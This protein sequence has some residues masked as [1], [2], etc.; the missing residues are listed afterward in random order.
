M[1][2]LPA[3]VADLTGV[4]EAL[5]G[6][7]AKTNDKF[8][9]TLDGDL[10]GYVKESDYAALNGRLSE[11]RNNNTALAGE[12]TALKQKLS[13]FEGVDPEEHK[14]LKTEAE[15]LKGKG[16]S[17]ADDI[18]VVV[19]TALEQALKPLKDQVSQTIAER[20]AEKQR[21]DRA[22]FRSAIQQEFTKA[23]GRAD[24]LDFIVGKADP[25]F[26]VKDDKI[27][28][29]ENRL[30][31]KGLPLTPSDWMA[32]TVKDYG[33]AFEP[34]KGAGGSGGSVNTP[35]AILSNPS[36]LDFGRNLEQIAKGSMT[37]T[38]E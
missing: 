28:A 18:A 32:R 20:N 37:V 6:F 22:L 21:A 14:A 29:R 30:N 35:N 33:F 25:E 13:A 5:R 16:V 10:P 34:S 11:F 23:G 36:P 27:V 17:K 24:A 26:E 7:Y 31:E 9:L 2:G 15:K 19:N 8:V 4:P 1:A 12:V 3:V 38:R